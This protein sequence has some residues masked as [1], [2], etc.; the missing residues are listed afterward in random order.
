[1]EISEALFDAVGILI[2]KKI[3][4]IKFDETI[5]ATVTDAK[6]ASS[7]EY[8]VSTGAAK[9][10]AYSYDTQYREKDV[11]LVTIPQ[12][13]YDNQKIIVSKKVVNQ[14]DPMVY[15]TPFEKF[16]NISNNLI[17]STSTYKNGLGIW[18]NYNDTK[19]SWPIDKEFNEVSLTPIWTGDY[20]KSPL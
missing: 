16:I 20:T 19:Y 3:Q 11:V 2:D 6:K 10:T 12:G 8:I 5:E 14:N 7:G 17:K 1:M 13:N 9:F 18:A 4:S 15:Q